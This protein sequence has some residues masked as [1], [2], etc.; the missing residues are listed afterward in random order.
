MGRKVIF[1]TELQYKL[2][3]KEGMA[4]HKRSKYVS[5]FIERW[6]ASS[7]S[8][9][10]SY[11]TRLQ[12]FTYYIFKEYNGLEVD[13]FVERLKNREIDVYEMLADFLVFVMKKRNKRF[14]MKIHSAMHVMYAV[15]V[16]LHSAGVDIDRHILRTRIPHAKSRYVEKA[17]L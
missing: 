3:G 4:H 1:G 17:A 7:P 8:T 14:K 10:G 5:K 16:F 15:T 13:S 9:A 6:F 2:Y 12:N 11:R